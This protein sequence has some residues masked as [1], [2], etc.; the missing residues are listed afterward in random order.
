M[1]DGTRRQQRKGV[2]KVTRQGWSDGQ[3][4][5]DDLEQRFVGEL[6]WARPWPRRSLWLAVEHDS[7]AMDKVKA[8]LAPNQGATV[9]YA[10]SEGYDARRPSNSE[11]EGGVVSMAEGHSSTAARQSKVGLRNATAR[12][13]HV[14]G[15]NAGVLNPQT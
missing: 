5:H 12:W 3:A 14:R 15:Q 6:G 2:F 10:C 9:L 11:V 4:R 8:N 7:G 13:A 1:S